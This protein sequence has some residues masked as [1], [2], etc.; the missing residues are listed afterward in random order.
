[1]CIHVVYAY[2]CVYV[3]VY[4]YIYIYIYVHTHTHIDT[5]MYSCPASGQALL[6]EGRAYS[7][8]Q[9]YSKGLAVETGCSDLYAVIY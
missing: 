3:C 2:M 9:H 4:I 5:S 8:N 1:M 7:K 6:F